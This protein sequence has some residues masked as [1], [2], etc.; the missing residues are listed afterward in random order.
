MAEGN[1]MKEETMKILIILGIASIVVSLLTNPQIAK[2]KRPR[3]REAFFYG[4]KHYC[5][6]IGIDIVRDG[7]L[8]KLLRLNN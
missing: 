5:K 3:V 8:T 2:M 1:Y 4:M 7:W 6:K